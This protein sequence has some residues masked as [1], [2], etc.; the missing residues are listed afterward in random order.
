MNTGSQGSKKHFPARDC[1]PLQLWGFEV[2]VDQVST[3][4]Y[5]GVGGRGGAAPDPAASQETLTLDR[6]NGSQLLP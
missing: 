2:K 3:F 6:A 1:I 5:L 4:G